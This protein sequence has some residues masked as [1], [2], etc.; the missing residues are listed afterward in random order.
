VKTILV[1]AA[2]TLA[3]CGGATETE[4]SAPHLLEET[5]TAPNEGPDERLVVLPLRQASKRA[6]LASLDSGSETT[7]PPDASPP[8]PVGACVEDMASRC[9]ALTEAA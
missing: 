2:L 3:A 9:L 8:A 7:P 1:L 4:T 5:I 6:P